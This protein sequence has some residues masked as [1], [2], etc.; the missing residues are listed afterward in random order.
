MAKIF[1]LLSKPGYAIYLS[2][3]CLTL[4][5]LPF[6]SPELPAGDLG[7]VALYLFLLWLFLILN[8]FLIGRRPDGQP[9]SGEDDPGSGP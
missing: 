8:L 1:K 4:F 5:C 3:L 9:P 7:P 2:F 6:I